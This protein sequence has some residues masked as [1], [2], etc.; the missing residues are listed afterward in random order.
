MAFNRSLFTGSKSISLSVIAIS[1]NVYY[2]YTLDEKTV[3]SRKKSTTKRV[4][5]QLTSKIY[6]F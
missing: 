6:L 1:K 4:K 5:M 2:T 3:K